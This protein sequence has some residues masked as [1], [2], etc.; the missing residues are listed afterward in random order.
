MQMLLL[1]KG[2]LIQKDFWMIDMV[3]KY[4]II[5]IVLYPVIVD[6]I[7]FA[8]ILAYLSK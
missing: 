2:I 7:A 4:N 5:M 8:L 3:T 1:G 6:W